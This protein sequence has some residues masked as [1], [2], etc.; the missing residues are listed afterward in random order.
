MDRREPIRVEL[1]ALTEEDFLRILTEPDNALI[2]QQQA[3]LGVE[4]LEV[5]G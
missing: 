1:S 3:L 5:Q 4:G 2:K